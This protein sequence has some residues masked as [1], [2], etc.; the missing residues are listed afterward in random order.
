MFLKIYIIYLRAEL[1]ILAA[2]SAGDLWLADL[3]SLESALDDFEN[4]F[5]MAVEQENAARRKASKAAKGK[6]SGVKSSAAAGKSSKAVKSKKSYDS[7]EEDDM[8]ED[9]DFDDDYDSD[10]ESKKVS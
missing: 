4:E 7:D 2:K 10:F 3:D 5:E 1:D 8:S 6:A 9:D